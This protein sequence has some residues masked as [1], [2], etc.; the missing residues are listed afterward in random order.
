MAGRQDVQCFDKTGTL[1]E[2]MLDIYGCQPILNGKF[3]EVE[4]FDRDKGGAE[5]P[6]PGLDLMNVAIATCHTVTKLR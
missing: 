4:K 1:T 2:D 5:D 3:E 6:I